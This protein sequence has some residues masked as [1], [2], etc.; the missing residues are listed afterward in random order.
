MTIFHAVGGTRGATLVELMV[1]TLVFSW[2]AL[3]GM[4]FLVLQH[5][6]SILQED[7]AEAQQQARAALDFMGRE[8][9][10]L[11]FGVPK[12]E[13]GLL[14][15]TEG[16]V[17]FLANIDASIA[18]LDQDAAAGEKRLSVNYVRNKDKFGQGK[19]VSICRLDRCEW[20][21]LAKDGGVNSLELSEGLGGPFPFGSM[22][23]VVKRLQYSLK[24][25]A[26][27]Q[28]KLD[29]TVDGGTNAVA[30]GLASMSLEY[31]DGKG[32]VTTTLVDIRRVRIRLIVPLP[33]NPQKTRSLFSEVYLR[34][35]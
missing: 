25:V 33:R 3:F 28:F 23:H 35:G 17:Q 2:A 12:D 4:R 20:H 5:K 22:I 29:R 30:E 13:I 16:E 34:N 27:A 18:W 1:A 11:G 31:L 19:T 32:R 7:M 9:A 14:K 26:A 15:A 24:P 21:S 6:W 10:L 8:L